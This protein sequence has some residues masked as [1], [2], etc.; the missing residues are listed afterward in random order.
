MSD[1]LGRVE[2]A[3]KNILLAG[4][5]GYI[6][7]FVA[8]ELTRRGYT[9]VALARPAPD[10]TVASLSADLPGCDVLIASF[11]DADALKR[12][13]KEKK[14]HAV[15][16]CIA[17]RNGAPDDAWRVDYDAN[18]QLLDVADELMA[19][20]FVL[21]SAICVQRPLLEFQHAKLA[22]EKLLRESRIDFSIVRPTA[23]FKSLAGQVGRVKAGK[24]FLVFGDGRL[25]A[26]KPI[27][28]V[29][30]ASF[31]VDCLE[32]SDKSNQ[33]LPVGGPGPAITPREQGALLCELAGKP[34]RL[35]QVTPRLFDVA[36]F[37][38][39]PLARIFPALRAKAEFA[40]IG[41]Y[42]ATESMLVWNEDTGCYDA[43]A[44]PSYGDDT[45]KD[46][47]QRVLQDGLEGQDLGEHK[48]F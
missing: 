4:A 15:V 28:E 26:C 39:A 36:E 43:A 9:V 34:V 35:R 27:S 22:F 42:Y 12:S 10:R 38:L 5:T 48:L 8:R 31:I 32:E 44:T 11:N 40:R 2:P 30:L 3:P 37:L 6:G 25:T 45:L 47:Y 16:S 23:Y 46:F 41:R 14:V 21:L 24:S 7:R 17:S 20:K 33:V 1:Q 13:I 29:D 19:S 18:R